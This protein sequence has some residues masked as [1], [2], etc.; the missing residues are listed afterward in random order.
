MCTLFVLC[1]EMYI[2][3]GMRIANK[4]RTVCVSQNMCRTRVTTGRTD[5]TRHP[6]P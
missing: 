4:Q 3:K 1:T 5:C 6:S 2:C